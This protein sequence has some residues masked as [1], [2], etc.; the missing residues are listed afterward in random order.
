[1]LV[2]T[3]TPIALSILFYRHTISA[4]SNN[5]MDIKKEKIKIFFTRPKISLGV[6]LLFITLSLCVGWFAA[7]TGDKEQRSNLSLVHR[8]GE[9]VQTNEL[10]LSVESVRHDETGAGPL[11]PRA[12]YE[13]IIP[14]ITLKNTSETSF[15]LIPLLYFHVKDTAGNVYTIVA[16]PSESNQL[17]GPILPHDMIREEIG[18]EVAKDAQGLSLY[19]DPGT[20]NQQTVVIDLEKEQP[21]K[22]FK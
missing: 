3:R 10:T 12:G 17:S 15:D 21:W 20:Q 16:I 22:L 1:M 5:S 14:T 11:T 8:I 13:F 18:F 2:G 9:Q 4:H 19:F 6:F 7:T